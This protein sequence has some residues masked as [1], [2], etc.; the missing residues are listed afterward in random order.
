MKRIKMEGKITCDGENG[1]EENWLRENV[2]FVNGI[3]RFIKK[4][5]R[6]KTIK[7]K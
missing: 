1:N 5:K 2:E 6:K 4:K 7:I 3:G